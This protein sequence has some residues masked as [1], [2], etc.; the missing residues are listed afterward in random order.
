[1][2]GSGQINAKNFSMAKQL[3]VSSK[4]VMQYIFRRALLNST[5]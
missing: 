4:V 3:L 2:F 1:M 5:T